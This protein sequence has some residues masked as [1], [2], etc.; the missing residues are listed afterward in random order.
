MDG[1]QPAR[2][3]DPVITEIRSRER[4][5]LI[6]LPKLRL[7]PGMRVRVISGPLCNQIGL[8]GALRPHER[9]LVL[10]RL[11]GG[12]QT[13]AAQDRLNIPRNPHTL[14]AGSQRLPNNRDL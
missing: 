13:T 3:P 5:G 1:E 11:L 9:V 2:V 7:D 10:L 14:F 4:G 8:L 6:E 12:E